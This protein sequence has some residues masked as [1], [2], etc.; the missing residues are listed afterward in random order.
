MD[1]PATS[2]GCMLLVSGHPVGLAHCVYFLN[3]PCVLGLLLGG[4]GSA[5]IKTVSLL[6]EN[7]GIYLQCGPCNKKHH[8]G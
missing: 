1:S 8:C 2:A 4:E 6:M 5:V 7:G 3:V